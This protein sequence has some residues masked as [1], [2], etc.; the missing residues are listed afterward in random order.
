MKTAG[1]RAG[2]RSAGARGHGMIPQTKERFLYIKDGLLEGRHGRRGVS[3][4]CVGTKRV[5]RAFRVAASRRDQ[6]SRESE[7]AP[8]TASP[9]C[10]FYGLTASVPLS[11]AKP[12]R[13]CP[14]RRIGVLFNSSCSN[15]RCAV[16]AR[17][18][19]VPQG[20]GYLKAV[21]HGRVSLDHK[22]VPLPVAIDQGLQHL[23]WSR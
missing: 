3:V 23:S 15:G 13:C 19:E 2:R 11:Q 5:F 7:P 1:Q 14:T 10:A 18:L 6:G 9:R 17:L 12:A 22:R 20:G 16:S 8:R 4:C 21:H